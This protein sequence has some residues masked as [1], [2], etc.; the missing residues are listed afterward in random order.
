MVWTKWVEP[1]LV[2]EPAV[3]CHEAE[4]DTYLVLGITAHQPPVKGT[5]LFHLQFGGLGDGRS[6][7]CTLFS[8]TVRHVIQELRKKNTWDYTTQVS[9]YF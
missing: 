5:L 8:T 7:K 9:E 1:G 4:E 6:F 3:T 2:R